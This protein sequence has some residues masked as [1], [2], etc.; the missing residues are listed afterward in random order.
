MRLNK[1]VLLGLFLLVSM[2][3][4]SCD[5]INP[6]AEHSEGDYTC[7]GCH[8]SRVMLTDV[9]EDLDLEAEEEGHEAPG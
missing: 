9:I 3:F 5:A 8:T 2:T 6:V 4:W 7:E 1:Q